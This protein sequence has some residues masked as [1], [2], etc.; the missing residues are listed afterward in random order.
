MPSISPSVSGA[1]SDDGSAEALDD[2]VDDAAGDASGVESAD[3]ESADGDPVGVESADGEPEEDSGAAASS[4]AS[5]CAPDGPELVDAHPASP[6]A[7]SSNPAV[8]SLAFR[9]MANLP[10]LIRF[11]RRDPNGSRRRGHFIHARSA[12]RAD[13]TSILSPLPRGCRSSSASA[14][15]SGT[16]CSP[17]RCRLACRLTRTLRRSQAGRPGAR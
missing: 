2:S 3:G 9:G 5:C 7:S 16:S 11:K 12:H 15:R 6:A 4:A 8:S 14:W 17:T 10:L 1:E 13:L